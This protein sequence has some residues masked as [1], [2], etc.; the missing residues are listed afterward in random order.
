MKQFKV[1]YA[2]VSVG[3]ITSRGELVDFHLIEAEFS[4]AAMAKRKKAQSVRNSSKFGRDTPVRVCPLS[5]V[6][7]LITDAEPPAEIARVCREA[8]VQSARPIMSETEN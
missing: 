1:K 7:M 8:G 3:G 6:S 2:I 4:R 5:D